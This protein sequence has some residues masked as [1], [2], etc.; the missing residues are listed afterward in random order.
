MSISN[1]FADWFKSDGGTRTIEI[2]VEYNGFM[3][4][5][6]EGKTMKCPTCEGN[7]S[8]NVAVYGQTVRVKMGTTGTRARSTMS[9]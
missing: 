6:C 7:V 4:H 1:Y 8:L 3:T 2:P 5:H 9:R